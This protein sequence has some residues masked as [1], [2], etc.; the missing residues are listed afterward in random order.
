MADFEYYTQFIL[1]GNETNRSFRHNFFPVSKKEIDV[2][3]ERLGFCL[4][5]ELVNFYLQIGYGFMFMH[6]EYAFNSL[7]HPSTIVAIQLREDQFE[8][9]PDLETYD[10]ASKILFYQVNE[11]IYLTMDHSK[12]TSGIYYFGNR[13]AESFHDFI[14]KLEQD[15]S[16]FESYEI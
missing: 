8:T 1:K 15:S 16:Y 2:A 11:G 7:L 5:Q 10:D 6:E 4:P 13:I 3:E 9:D 14:N 12:E